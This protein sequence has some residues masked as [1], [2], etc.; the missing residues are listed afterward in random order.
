MRS[1]RS[2][3]ALGLS[4]RRHARP[5]APCRRPFKPCTRLELEEP[6]KDSLFRRPQVTRLRQG[7]GEVVEAMPEHSEPAT[8]TTAEATTGGFHHGEPSLAPHSLEP[9]CG[10]RL[11]GK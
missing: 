8:V 7:L 11:T 6:I 4:G 10:P 2:S 5:G 1:V 3:A 9:L